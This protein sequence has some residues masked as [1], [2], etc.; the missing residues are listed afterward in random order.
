MEP[1]FKNNLCTKCAKYGKGRFPPLQHL[2]LHPPF[3]FSSLWVCALDCGKNMIE[4]FVAESA[5]W[6]RVHSSQNFCLLFKTILFQYRHY[7]ALN[8]GWTWGFPGGSDSKESAFNAGDLDLILG[9][10]RSPREGNGNPLR[11]SCLENSLD[12]GAWR[13]TVHGITKSWTRL[14]D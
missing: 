14:N 11:Y 2:P 5:T 3:L 13:P 9:L 7:I 4:S 8:L 10:G 1:D 12:R 6:Y